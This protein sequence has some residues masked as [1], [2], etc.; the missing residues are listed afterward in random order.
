VKRSIREEF[1]NLPNSI[2]LVRI[3]MIPVSVGFLAMDT[4]VSCYWATVIFALASATDFLDGWV[5]R[6]WNLITITGKFLD[7]LA[8]KLIVISALV[9]LLSFGRVP[10]WAV[11]LIIVR[12]L[13]ITSLRA[14]AA[15]EGMVMAA[16]QEGKWKAALQMVGLV[17]LMV[18]YPHTVDFG[19]YRVYFHFHDAGL[20]ILYLSLFFSLLSAGKYLRWFVGEADRRHEE[21]KKAHS[22]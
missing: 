16:G 9:M 10:A 7:P 22:R 1:L 17:G 19:V 5:A 6:R 12:E 15:G 2:T 8:D 14:L 4:P 13:A 18:H 21:Y 3:C 20:L 11:I